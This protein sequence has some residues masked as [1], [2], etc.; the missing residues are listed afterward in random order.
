MRAERAEVGRLGD[1]T[2]VTVPFS[3]ATTFKKV[4]V[5]NTITKIAEDD[6][7]NTQQT[8]P[9]LDTTHECCESLARS[10]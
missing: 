6:P 4:P 5:A 8:R 2:L 9:R 7:L 3:H 1:S 10:I